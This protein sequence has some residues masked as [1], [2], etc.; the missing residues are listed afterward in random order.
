MSKKRKMPNFR[1]RTNPPVNERPHVHET[2]LSLA[3]YTPSLT[4]HFAYVYVATLIGLQRACVA[5]GVGFS[6]GTVVGSSILPTARNRCCDRFMRSAATHMLFLDGDVGVDP[7]DILTMM[8]LDLEFSTLPY[9]KRVV[10]WPRAVDAI[11]GVKNT[12][13][14]VLSSLLATP[15]FDLPMDQKEIPAE[16][17]EH[18]FVRVNHAATGAMLLKRSVFEK[19]NAA[20]LAD[21][22]VEAINIDPAGSQGPDGYSVTGGPLNPMAEY[23]NYSKDS[24]N[25][26]VGEDYT[27]CEKWRSLGGE[28]YMKITAKTIHTGEMNFEFDFNEMS[29]AAEERYPTG[30]PTEEDVRNLAKQKSGHSSADQG[31]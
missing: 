30:G 21:Q 20:G 27:F 11:Q 3:V 26:F 24:N 31:E 10:D 17:A 9:S 16:I 6:W 29:K 18:G 19:I 28:I 12:N 22:I 25:L 23:F 5:N 13:P 2:R 14:Q 15:A 4:G 1:G 8:A 7:Q